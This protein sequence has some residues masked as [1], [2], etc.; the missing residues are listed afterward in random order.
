MPIKDYPLTPV[1]PGL[2]RPMLW[3]RVFNPT[4][5]RGI[6][7]L[8]IVDTGADDSV[9]P[10][11][12]TI[13]LG[14]KPKAV[15]PKKIETASGTVKVCIHKYKPR[16]DILEMRPDGM[17]GGKI[18]HTIRNTPINFIRDCDAFLLGTRNFLNKFVLRIDYPRQVFS[19]RKPKK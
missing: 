14:Y 13:Q 11:K 16:V 12:V 4:T 8:A 9:F 19:I 5:Q 10:G 18:L 6:I 2:A 3:I 17:P 1:A 15:T 7:A